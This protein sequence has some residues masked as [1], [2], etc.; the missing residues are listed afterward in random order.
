M[1]KKPRITHE[2]PKAYFY[3]QR[4]PMGLIQNTGVGVGGA[5]WE[6]TQT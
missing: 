6:T 2:R 4:G 3:F 5:D 1:L